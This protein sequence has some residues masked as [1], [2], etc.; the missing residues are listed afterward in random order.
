MF[1]TMPD[2]GQMNL[3][4]CFRHCNCRMAQMAIA[5]NTRHYTEKAPMDIINDRSI[6]NAIGC[7]IVIVI[8]FSVGN[9]HRRRQWRRRKRW[10]S[11]VAQQSAPAQMTPSGFCDNLIRASDSN[12]PS[13]RV[14]WSDAEKSIWFV[15]SSLKI[16]MPVPTLS[17]Q[18]N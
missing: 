12:F 2:S 16:P 11:K 13:K 15:F 17:K 18:I 8:I 3:H 6:R 1:S 4:L 9:E 7:E 14:K 10:I 5:R